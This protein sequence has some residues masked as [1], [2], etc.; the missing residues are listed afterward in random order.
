MLPEDQ[1]IP[2]SGTLDGNNHYI[3]NL[4]VKDSR[5]SEAPND[6]IISVGNSLLG[7]KVYDG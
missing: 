6:V 2:F 4:Y 1:Q 7:Y 5:T 3:Y